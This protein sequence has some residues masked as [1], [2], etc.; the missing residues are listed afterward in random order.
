MFVYDNMS[1]II[2]NLYLGGFLD[3]QNYEQYDVIISI[4]PLNEI[5]NIENKLHYIIDINDNSD[6]D[7]L[8]YF[9]GIT[10]IIH[11]YLWQNKKILV[12]CATGTSCSAIIAM[13]YLMR[14]QYASLNF[15]Y[16]RVK[17]RR[18]FINPKL[19]FIKQLNQY[20]TILNENHTIERC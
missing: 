5:L 3:A 11:D 6:D 8:I 9:N 12:H 14:Y 15:A 20:E 10:K 16:Y 17:A 13:A 7:M 18:C 2:S 1:I 4:C 19:T